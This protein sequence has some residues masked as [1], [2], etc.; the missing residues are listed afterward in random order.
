M[1][2]IDK[3][4]EVQVTRDVQYA[5]GRVGANSNAR[6]RPL[7]LDAYEPESDPAGTLRPALIMAFGGAFHRGSKEADEFDNEG[8]RNTP[9]AQ[10]CREFARRGYAAFSIDY[11]LV[12][13]DPDP[14]I[15]PVILNKRNIPRSRLDHVR[16]LLG[17]P[18]ATSEMIWA[19]MEAACD[20]MEKAFHF[21]SGNASHYRI[22]PAR[23][24]IGG[25]SAGART[26]LCVAYGAR[27][28]AAAIIAISGY[29]SEEDLTR[30]VTGA[31]GEPPALLVTGEHDLDYV[32]KQAAVLHRHFETVGLH[33]ESWT[34]PGAT[35][36]YPASSP[37]R[38]TDGQE[39][40]L[41]EAMANFLYRA[42]RLGE[43]PQ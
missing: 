2:F 34:V 27:V 16:G 33:H 15:T 24:A 11:R 12:Q 3:S 13:E 26:A 39:A 5:T 36:F 41:E 30:L 10:Y 43:M 38:R 32:A 37:L 28:P 7:C 42:L 40:L 9:V 18:P 6:D 35:H 17:L 22:D 8:H 1:R 29:M 21:V 25:F 4:F 14:G 23:I 20:D 31:A 19:G